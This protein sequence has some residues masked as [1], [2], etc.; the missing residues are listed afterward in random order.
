M[1]PPSSAS[2]TQYSIQLEL[3]DDRL[4]EQGRTVYEAIVEVFNETAFDPEFNQTRTKKELQKRPVI[5]AQR[6]MT[7]SIQDPDEVGLLDLVFSAGLTLP[8]NVT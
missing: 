1:S 4:E 2:G 8:S 7:V 6:K 3:V 5:I